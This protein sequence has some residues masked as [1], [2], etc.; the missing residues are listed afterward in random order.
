MFN[1]EIFE[2]L[3]ENDEKKYKFE[4]WDILDQ[5][6]LEEMLFSG[7]SDQYIWDF[8]YEMQDNFNMPSPT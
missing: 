3:D 7:R 4:I 5:K 1:F 8:P 2:V 6:S